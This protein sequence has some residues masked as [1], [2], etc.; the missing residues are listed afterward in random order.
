[1]V[2]GLKEDEL[3]T[4]NSDKSGNESETTNSVEKSDSEEP[5][6]MK[7]KRTRRQL[8]LALIWTSRRV[9]GRQSRNSEGAENGLKS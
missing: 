8:K 2:K 6:H 9:E 5:N 3:E 7:A 4:S 1:M